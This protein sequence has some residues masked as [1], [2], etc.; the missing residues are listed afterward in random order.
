MGGYVQSKARRIGPPGDGT[1]AAKADPKKLLAG[2]DALSPDYKLDLSSKPA[3]EAA[4]SSPTLTL[5]SLPSVPT[6]PAPSAPKVDLPDIPK[7]AAKETATKEIKAAV[8]EKVKDGSVK[9]PAIIFIKGLDIFSSPSKSE[10]GYA[11]V[12]KIADS[13][14]G[15]K[16]FSWSE[17]DK[18]IDEV[19]KTHRDYPVILVGHS[20]GGD[21]AIEVAEELDSLEH[22]FRTIDLLVTMDAI[23]FDHDIIPQNVKQHLNVF[24]EKNI[25]LNDGPHV[26]RREDKTTVRNILSPEDHID[27]DD[28]KE[29]QFEV[30]GLIQKT[31]G[32]GLA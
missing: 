10:R 23:G 18:I 8:V 26:A 16:V 20:L 9:K 6:P 12:G 15:S 2:K 11:G 30:V 4:S 29:I 14:E 22:M 21:T 1:A 25:F 19:R 5:P 32:P 27:I 7:E 24:G 13:I 3:A 17:Q 31:L 28:S